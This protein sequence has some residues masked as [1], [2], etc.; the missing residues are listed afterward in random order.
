MPTILKRQLRKKT[1]QFLLD[2]RSAALATAGK[3][4]PPHVATIFFVPRK[5]LTLYFTTRTSGR[6][7]QNLIA[8][9]R[10]AMAITDDEKLITVQLSGVTEQVANP[11]LER[12][13]LQDLWLFRH[14]D[15]NWPIPPM[16][17]YERGAVDDL[18]V[19]KVTP[20]EMSYA[21][22]EIATTG[23]YKSFFHRVI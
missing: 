20:S 21:N 6:K 23:K 12:E 7:F 17:L 11:R 3:K 15:P 18:A 4:G 16:K 1:Y 10:V 19:I 9:P 2:N 8:Q 5:N 22:F 14:K 13:I